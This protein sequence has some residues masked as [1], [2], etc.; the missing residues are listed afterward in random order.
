MNAF[1][2]ELNLESPGAILFD[3]IIFWAIK[4]SLIEVQ[5]KMWYISIFIRLG[6]IGKSKAEK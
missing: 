4:Y 3:G 5:M 6:K 1:E 2:S